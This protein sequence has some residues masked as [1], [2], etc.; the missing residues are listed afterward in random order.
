MEQ[1]LR[2]RLYASLD[3]ELPQ[4]DQRVIEDAL[5][6]YQS[7]LLKEYGQVTRLRSMIGRMAAD[8]FEPFFVQRVMTAV[9]SLSGSV[10]ASKLFFEH[11]K[12]WYRMT[13]V[14]G[15]TLILALIS[16]NLIVADHVSLGAAFGFERNS[17]NTIWATPLE[18]IIGVD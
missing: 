3:D 6:Q 12:W 17:S 5:E 9:E 11:A 7:P 10:K 16:V 18:Q 4:Q 8:R 2:K 14:V 13:M 1:G 15:T